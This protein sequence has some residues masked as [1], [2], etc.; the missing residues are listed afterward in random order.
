V[1]TPLIG[2]TNV[3][4][5]AMPD[6]LASSATYRVS[7]ANV[8]AT[9]GTPCCAIEWDFRTREIP[10]PEGRPLAPASLIAAGVPQGVRLSWSVPLDLDRR[11]VEVFRREGEADPVP[12]DAS[13]ELVGQFA[14]GQIA[15]D[16][17]TAQAGHTYRYA[18]RAAD[19]DPPPKVSDLVMSPPVV[20]PTPAPPAPP[21]P[22]AA[23]VTQTPAPTTGTTTTPR[24]TR[25]PRPTTRRSAR[26]ILP[27]SVT[28]V[29]AR[30]ALTVTWRRDRRARYYNV[31]L[32]RGTRKLLSVHPS[33]TRTVIPA[34][35]LT[36][37]SYRLLVWSGLGA[38]SAGR[39][40]RV[41]WLD[42]T[43]RVRAAPRRAR[44]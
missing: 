34:R 35:R 19:R 31:Q 20:V 26:L 42:Q 29:R 27:R 6:D 36:P 3:W 16:D 4:V 15:F 33:R 9:D 40:V 25:A 5:L 17:T 37:G 12:G 43:L 18:I 44:R 14:E 23:P 10:E 38:R 30:R 21:A 24:P 39:Y 13:T 11:Y 32:L 8:T 41:P 2:F 28:A 1:P 22:P 7:V